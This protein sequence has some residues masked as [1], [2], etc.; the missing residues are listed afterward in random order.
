MKTNTPVIVSLISLF[1]IC[2]L[3]IACSNNEATNRKEAETNKITLPDTSV[4]NLSRII[5]L[6]R[7][8]PD[9][10]KYIYTFHDNSGNN[11]RAS[12]PGPSD[13]YLEAVL[14]FKKT[15][16]EKLQKQYSSSQASSLTYKKESFIFDWLNKPIKD[17]IANADS[18]VTGYTDTLFGNMIDGKILLINNKALLI[19]LNNKL[20]KTMTSLSPNIFVTDINK[21]IEFYK[22]LGFITIAT[23][24]EE[25]NYVWAMVKCGDVTFMFQTYESLGD[26]LPE[27][28]RTDGGSLLF[29]IN[30]KGI[31]VF[32]EKLKDKVTIVKGL[33]KMFYGAT[34]LL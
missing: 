26:S 33:E 18:T 10:V 8:N 31:R 11:N 20:Y 25:G 34:E 17:E 19:N 21:T 29:Y 14:Y 3:G 16:F 30:V 9:S 13:S 5:D 1:S 27:I 6:S 23:V 32:F 7:Y 22:Q 2:C 4:E 28:H 15:D 12:V 24:P